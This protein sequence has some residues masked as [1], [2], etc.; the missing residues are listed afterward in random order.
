MKE[1]N[2]PADIYFEKVVKFRQEL[3]K[4]RKI[5]LD[6]GLTE[7][8]KW[9]APIYTYQQKNLVAIGELSDH[10]VLSFFKGALLANEHGLLEKPGEN[11]QSARVIRFTSGAQVDQLESKLRAL[12]YEAVE[13]EKAGLKVTFKKISE[14]R[15][16]LP[17]L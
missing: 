4:L 15:S 2:Q 7:E 12:I 14:L 13:A 10:F 9:H 11:T 3:E 16:T 8:L 5:V 6:C 1:K 17:F